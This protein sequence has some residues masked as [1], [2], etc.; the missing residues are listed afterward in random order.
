MSVEGVVDEKGPG[1]ELLIVRLDA[2]ARVTDRAQR[3][4]ERVA[5]G[6]GGDVGGVHDA[7]QFHQDRVAAQLV[8]V[9]ESLKCAPLAAV[10][11]AAGAVGGAG[12][13]EG[14]PAVALRGGENVGGRDV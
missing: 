5:V 8:G 14:G 1:E 9:D 11:L 3:R 2:A 7:G 12:R 4:P 10:W 13:G 6:V